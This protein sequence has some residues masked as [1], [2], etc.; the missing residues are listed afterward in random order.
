MFLERG[1]F[2]TFP[3]EWIGVM[4]FTNWESLAIFG[5]IAFGIGN[6]VAS[7]YGFLKKDKKIFM[8]TIFMGVLLL[9]CAF[10]PVL[11]V[12]EW[13]LPT[14]QFLLAGSIQIILGLLGL[15]IRR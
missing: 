9:L 10:S 4:P 5:I 6:A 12:G 2:D 14:I 13:Y 15:A 3:A 11:L 8:A 7:A 1:V